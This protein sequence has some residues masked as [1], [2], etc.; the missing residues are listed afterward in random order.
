MNELAAQPSNFMESQVSREVQE[1]Q[2]QLIMAKKF[3]RS[4][5][6][7]IANIMEAC[8]R[9]SLAENASY[10]YPR[11]GEQ[12]TG[13]SIRL[14]EE[15]ARQ[16]GNIDFG[17]KELEQRDGESVVMSYAWDL[18]TNARQTKTFTVPHSR[19]TKKDG[20]K[21]LTDPRDIYELVA[22]NGARRLRACILGII[23]GY[24]T[25]EAVEACERTMKA[26]VESEP[27][28][29]QIAKAIGAFK[30]IGVTVEML[31]TFLKHKMEE[32]NQ[33]ELVALRKIYVGIST[34]ASTIS[35][36]F[37]YKEA[38]KAGSKSKADELNERLQKS[39]GVEQENPGSNQET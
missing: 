22:N 8:K 4:V 5:P 6:N 13:P 26:T 37:N 9:K 17:I 36:W 38:S 27:L 24:I 29:D 33:T 39:S 14:A 10:L 20:M 11:G 3:P 31:E 2:G 35:Q 18:E 12:V 34:G 25:E 28:N 23:P 15:L 19:F 21:K 30:S 16:Y 7:V 1:V 32:T